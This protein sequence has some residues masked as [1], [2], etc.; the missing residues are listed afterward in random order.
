M[1][2]PRELLKQIFIG[3]CLPRMPH[4]CGSGMNSFSLGTG[5]NL[6][7]PSPAR[8]ARSARRQSSTRC[9]AG[10]R[11]RPPPRNIARAPRAVDLTMMHMLCARPQD[12]A[13]PRSAE[14]TNRLWH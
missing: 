13:N 14:E 2:S 1:A 8:C 11:A 12:V 9:S 5:V 3:Q 7:A 10:L 4:P 6:A